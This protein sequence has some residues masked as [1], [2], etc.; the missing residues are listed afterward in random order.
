MK[1]METASYFLSLAEK[2]NGHLTNLKLQKLLY[3]AQAWHIALY[4]K[5]LF[6]DKIEAWT[7]GPVI[8]EVYKAYKEHCHSHICLECAK[9]KS[10]PKK[11][12]AFLL[13]IYENFMPFTAKELTH[14]TH[15]EEPWLKT[16]RK[17]KV[18]VIPQKLMGSFYS[19]LLKNSKK[20]QRKSA[21]GKA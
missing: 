10:L 14:M 7:F 21:R 6:K 15:S 1:A 19:S 16:Y 11:S 2:N 5:P 20:N 3:Y 4:K 12:E 17:D 18:E 8:K 9:P 13:K